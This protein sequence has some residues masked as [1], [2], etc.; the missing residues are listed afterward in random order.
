MSC[1]KC[2]SPSATKYEFTVHLGEDDDPFDKKARV[3]GRGQAEVCHECARKNRKNKII[4]VLIAIGVLFVG[5]AIRLTVFGEREASMLDIGGVFLTLGAFYGL[6]EMSKQ[7]RILMGELAAARFRRDRY[8]KDGLTLEPATKY[9]SDN[10][11]SLAPFESLPDLAFGERPKAVGIFF[12]ESIVAKTPH[13]D[14]CG[15]ER[16]E[17][18]GLEIPFVAGWIRTHSG[19]G[20]HEFTWYGFAPFT[21]TACPA[22]L[23]G[24]DVPTLLRSLKKGATRKGREAIAANQKDDKPLLDSESVAL[25]TPARFREFQLASLKK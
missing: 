12:P 25:F 23:Q 17:G 4:G 11:K 8:L 18:A 20:Y 9:R 10:D 14:L 2:G 24:K 21:F 7:K 22:C 6:Y 5:L 1:E 3:L 16:G 19:A 13:C 15:S